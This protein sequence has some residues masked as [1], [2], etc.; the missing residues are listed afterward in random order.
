M[1]PWEPCETKDEDG[2]LQDNGRVR[3]WKRRL[4]PAAGFISHIILWFIAYFSFSCQRN[5]H[6][7][8]M[9]WSKT[10]DQRS[11]WP[12]LCTP[13]VRTV[14]GEDTHGDQCLLLFSWHRRMSSFTALWRRGGWVRRWTPPHLGGEKWNRTRSLQRLDLSLPLFPPTQQPNTIWVRWRPKRRNLLSISRT[15][16]GF[17][18]AG[19]SWQRS[20]TLACLCR[21]RMD[22]VEDRSES[23]TQI[24][25]TPGFQFEEAAP[26]WGEVRSLAWLTWTCVNEMR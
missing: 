26:K 3:G 15:S 4:R 12:Y 10:K 18:Y 23:K 14:T 11:S 2:P 16:Q 13:A 7:K 17:E 22:A 19:R 1:Q 8:T 21:V 6:N 5:F 25:F 9:R 20:Q 24:A